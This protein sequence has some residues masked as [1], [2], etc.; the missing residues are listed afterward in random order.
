MSITVWLIEV[1][2]CTGEGSFSRYS[3]SIYLDSRISD[4]GVWQ[5]R[6]WRLVVLMN[7]HPCYESLLR[8]VSL[9]I[10][11]AWGWCQAGGSQSG[12]S[13]RPV[14]LSCA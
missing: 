12:E 3:R 5:G 13:N 1:W 6:Q 4:W 7:S 10:A 9:A 11:H 2:G 14:R 8:F